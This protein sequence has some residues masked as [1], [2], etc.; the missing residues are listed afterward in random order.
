MCVHCPLSRRISAHGVWCWWCVPYGEQHSRRL[1]AWRD[2]WLCFVTV[3]PRSFAS[4]GSEFVRSIVFGGMDGILTSVGIVASIFGADLAAKV[5]TS[6]R[7]EDGGAFASVGRVRQLLVVTAPASPG[8]HRR[9]VLR[10]FCDVALPPCARGGLPAGACTRTR[11]PVP[12]CC[13]CGVCGRR[14]WPP[15]F[16]VARR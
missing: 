8:I 4:L 12:E 15:A 1:R 10:Y 13:L 5:S 7:N 11:G 2:A 3:L 16:P 9:C 6:C 14:H